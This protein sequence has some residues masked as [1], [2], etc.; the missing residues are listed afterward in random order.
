MYRILFTFFFLGPFLWETFFHIHKNNGYYCSPFLWLAI[1]LSRC[2]LVLKQLLKAA[3]HVT[4]SVDRLAKIAQS[5]DD[6]MTFTV[7]FFSFASLTS[8]WATF[9]NMLRNPRIHQLAELDVWYLTFTAS[10]L[11]VPTHCSASRNKIKWNIYRTTTKQNNNIK[12]NR[13]CIFFSFY[14]NKCMK[15]NYNISVKKHLWLKRI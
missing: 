7:S 15:M 1:I 12:A 4:V 6:S 9:L 13:D 5:T 11:L 2:Y 14:C 3:M 10:I 8:V